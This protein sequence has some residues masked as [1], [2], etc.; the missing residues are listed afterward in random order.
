MHIQIKHMTTR[1]NI[2]SLRQWEKNVSHCTVQSHNTKLCEC[3]ISINHMYYVSFTLQAAWSPRKER[4][5]PILY[6]GGGAL[7]CL[8]GCCV[9]RQSSHYN[10]PRRPR[11]GVGIYLY[12]FFNLGAWS[13]PRPGSFTPRKETR[14]PMYRRLGRP[15]AD[16]DGWG[17]PYPHPDSI[18]GPLA[19]I[20]APGCRGEDK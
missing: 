10:R 14:Y 2:Q 12:F 13:K 1:F 18:P 3:T 19:A 5:V 9:N 17:K 8:P 15:T 20:P 7:Y 4:L 11:A 16:M 6:D